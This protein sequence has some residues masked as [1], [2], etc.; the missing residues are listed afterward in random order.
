MPRNDVILLA[1]LMWSSDM[2]VCLSRLCLAV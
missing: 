2:A 1:W